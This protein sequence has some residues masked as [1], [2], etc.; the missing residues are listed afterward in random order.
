MDS[1]SHYNVRGDSGS[2]P[3]SPV[4]MDGGQAS[5]APSIHEQR[6]VVGGT[7]DILQQ[8]AQ[9]LQRV[10]QPSAIAPQ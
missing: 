6:Q 4:S 2:H 3:N 9:A 1:S 7:I 8:I 10:A 5:H